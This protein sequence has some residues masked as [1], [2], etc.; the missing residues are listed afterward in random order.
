M[1]W[2]SKIARSSIGKKQIVALTGLALCGFLVVHLAGNLLLFAGQEAFDGY[3]EVLSSHPL[4]IPAEVILALLFLGHIA[5]A[6][7]VTWENRRARPTRYTVSATRGERTVASSTMIASGLV[8]LVFIILHLIDFKVAWEKGTSLYDLVVSKFQ[9]PFYVI[10]YVF[11][12]CVLGL[13]VSHGVQSSFRS[14]GV[15]HPKYTPVIETIGKVFAVI[16]VV[17]YASLPIYAYF[18]LGAGA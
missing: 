2:L 13:H 14:L 9:G 3:V 6:I 5:L 4:I 12:V 11:A 15:V 8:V 17:G 1:A 18:F 10:W 7:R 16:V